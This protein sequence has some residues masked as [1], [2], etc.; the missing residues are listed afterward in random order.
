MCFNGLVDTCQTQCGINT[1][2]TGNWVTPSS[3]TCSCYDG[4]NSPTNDGKVCI[5]LKPSAVF[6]FDSLVTLFTVLLSDYYPSY[7]FYNNNNH[8]YYYY[9]ACC[10]THDF[11]LV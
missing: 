3:M 8:D 11:L 7:Y 1:W 4:Y 5:G 10:H 9:Y 6:V 2:C